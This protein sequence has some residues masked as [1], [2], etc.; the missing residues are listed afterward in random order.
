MKP[1]ST[2]VY[3][4]AFTCQKSFHT[5]MEEA[6]RH[7]GV[8]LSVPLCPSSFEIFLCRKGS[9]IGKGLLGRLSSVFQS[10]KS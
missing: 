8:L 9:L 6:S 3:H 5:Y 2:Q 10:Q 1:Q 4:V 7:A